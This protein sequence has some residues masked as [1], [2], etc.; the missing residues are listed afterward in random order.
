MESET[1]AGE[2]K[3]ATATGDTLNTPQIL[4][5]LGEVPISVRGDVTLSGKTC[6]Q[7]PPPSYLVFSRGKCPP[8]PQSRPSPCQS[9]TRRRRLFPVRLWRLPQPNNRLV[10]DI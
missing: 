1:A 6:F 8:P 10:I 7:T 9:I 3:A 5:S 2:E 4:A